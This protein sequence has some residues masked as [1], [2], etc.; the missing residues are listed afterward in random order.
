MAPS[1]Y[2]EAGSLL[3]VADGVVMGAAAVVVVAAG[4][5]LER[6]AAPGEAVLAVL[7][8][9][10][11]GGA[12]G[13]RVVVVADGGRRG[14]G[15]RGR[16]R[17]R[18]VGALLQRVR[19]LNGDTTLAAGR[20]DVALHPD[21]AGLAPAAAPRVLHDP[22]VLAVL[23]A[24]ADGRDTMVQRCSTGSCEDTLRGQEK[25]ISHQYKADDSWS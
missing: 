6:A 4:G 12:V 20:L 1:I 24:V 18:G 17:V 11:A 22:V 14:G 8:D 25:M 2:H 9:A 23:C 10:A 3:D 5:A 7:I 16:P 21:V 15:R 13:A 19:R